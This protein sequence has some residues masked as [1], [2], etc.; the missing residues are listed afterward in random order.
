MGRLWSLKFFSDGG[1]KI[2]CIRG[3][4]IRFRWVVFFVERG[5]LF[6]GMEGG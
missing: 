5:E 6:I 3:N 4:K 1:G 2:S